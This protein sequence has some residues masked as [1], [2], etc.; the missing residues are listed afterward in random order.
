MRE[1]I[2]PVCKEPRGSSVCR[3]SLVLVEEKSP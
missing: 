2:C 3:G 1:D